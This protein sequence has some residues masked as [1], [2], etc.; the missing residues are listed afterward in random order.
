MNDDQTSRGGLR[1]AVTATLLILAALAAAMALHG[2]APDAYYQIVQ[3]DEVVE[4]STFWAFMIA[5]AVGVFAA[6]RQRRATGKLPWFLLGVALFCL[7]VGMEEISWGQRVVGYR[8][9]VYFLEN[10][11]QQE[12]NVHNVFSTQLRKFVLKGVILGF[13]VILPALALVPALGRRLRRAAVVPPPAGLAPA[14]LVTYLL[15]EAYPWTHTGEWVEL[16]LGLGFLFAAAAAVRE[17]GAGAPARRWLSQPVTLAGWW[18]LVVALGATNA[19]V[20]RSQRA[21]HPENVTAARAEL[22]ALRRDFQSGEVRSRCGVHKRIYSFEKKYKQD[23]LLGGEFAALTSQG[24]PA[25]RA[26]FFL[27]PWNSPY[28]IRDEC[29]EVQRRRVIFVYSFGPDRR[30]ASTRWEVRGDDVGAVIHEVGGAKA[31]ESGAEE[32]QG[33]EG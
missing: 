19:A 30:R 24:L 25:E 28:W 23:H 13:G 1:A 6:L 16:M 11:F 12:L 15:Y 31:G 5:A 8:P 10:N 17:F 27:D 20:A 22:E 33:D 4:W 18:L 14:F 32:E 3:E 9:P 7:F 29:D 21:A 2:L 26:E